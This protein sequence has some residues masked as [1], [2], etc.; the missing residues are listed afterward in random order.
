M[1]ENIQFSDME[2]P[3]WSVCYLKKHKHHQ[4]QLSRRSNNQNLNISY[5]DG[6]TC[7]IHSRTS[8]FNQQSTIEI[9]KISL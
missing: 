2:G 3:L 4:I 7:S 6:N 5:T 1:A 9:K 8:N